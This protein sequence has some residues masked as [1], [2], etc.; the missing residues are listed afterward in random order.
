MLED[1]RPYI[2]L[3]GCSQ[4]YATTNQLDKH[5]MGCWWHRAVSCITLRVSEGN[6][7]KFERMI[8]VIVATEVD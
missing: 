3:Q 8:A 5:Y 1:E 4:N 2:V 6:V 7:F